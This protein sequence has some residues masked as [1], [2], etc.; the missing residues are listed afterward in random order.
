MV[1]TGMARVGVTGMA[2]MGVTGMARIG[3]FWF[4]VVM[5]V[6][7]PAMAQTLQYDDDHSLPRHRSDSYSGDRD[8]RARRHPGR[9]SRLALEPSR[10]GPAPMGFWY[11]CDAPAGF[12][13]YITA[14]L[15]PWHMVPST[16]PR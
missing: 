10:I 5:L 14:C 6:G 1:A 2:R 13:P 3:R 4:C 11:R 7:A 16:P 8:H 9:L 12:Y 15:T